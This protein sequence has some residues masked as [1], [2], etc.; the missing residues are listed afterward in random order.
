MGSWIRKRDAEM[1]KKRE[2]EIERSFCFVVFLHF[3]SALPF[4]REGMGIEQEQ[5]KIHRTYA[6]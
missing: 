6:T 1:E 5:E 3:E 2:R 4:K